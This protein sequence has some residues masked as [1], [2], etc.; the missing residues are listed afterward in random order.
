M[1]RTAKKRTDFVAN[2]TRPHKHDGILE[3]AKRVMNNDVNISSIN[4]ILLSQEDYSNQM[5][6]YKASTNNAKN[7]P[8]VVIPSVDPIY[9]PV[10]AQAISD[11]GCMVM[12]QGQ[13]AKHNV[14]PSDWKSHF[15]Q[16]SPGRYVTKNVRML[17]IRDL[18]KNV[19]NP[20]QNLIVINNQTYLIGDE[21]K[22]AI[23]NARP[24]KSG[25]YAAN[26]DVAKNL[27]LMHCDI[28]DIVA[29]FNNTV[30]T[31]TL[32]D[33]TMPGSKIHFL[34]NQLATWGHLYKDG[35]VLNYKQIREESLENTYFVPLE[36][37]ISGTGFTKNSFC[38]SV[39]SYM[40]ENKTGRSS[41]D[42]YSNRANKN[43]ESNNI[44]NIWKNLFIQ[45]RV[46]PD[47]WTCFGFENLQW[48]IVPISYFGESI[49]EQLVR[50]VVGVRIGANYKESRPNA[51]RRVMPSNN[52][53]SVEVV[54]V[55]NPEILET[56]QSSV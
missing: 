40:T 11:L 33:G 22:S 15:G 39:K 37:P 21:T 49:T 47:V 46:S 36:S 5:S 7:D 54:K 31:E 48:G 32:D 17:H 27:S 35:Q 18:R 51:R 1:P 13:A 12:M 45:M 26:M 29:Q 50:L 4:G 10:V 42:R 53:I 52:K 3:L 23:W 30:V 19:L 24:S 14:Q 44:Q 38:E 2:I 41:W 43:E 20:D 55:E 56:E 9:D 16:W 8:D 34:P 25:N 6:A 28:N